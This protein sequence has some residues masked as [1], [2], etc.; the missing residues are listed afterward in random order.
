MLKFHSLACV[1]AVF[2]SL[3]SEETFFSLYIILFFVL[4]QLTIYE[5]FCFCTVYSVP[6]IYVFVFMPVWYCFHYYSFVRQFELGSMMASTLFF[7]LNIFWLFGVF[8]GFIQILGL[9]HF[10]EK[11]HWNFDKVYIA[12]VWWTWIWTSSRS[13][14]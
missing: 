14:W 3:Y 8:C 5:W 7:F 6:L 9:F 12:P 13:W 11:C 4:S 10:C 1:C 2:S